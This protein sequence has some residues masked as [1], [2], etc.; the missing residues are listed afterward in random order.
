MQD[1]DPLWGG[2]LKETQSQEERQRQGYENLKLLSPMATM[3]SKHCSTPSQ[4]NKD[5]HTEDKYISVL[6]TW[7]NM[8]GFQQK[9]TKHAKRKKEIV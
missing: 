7:S 9:I 8:S 4:I 2:I 5:P 1:T 3:N 6:V